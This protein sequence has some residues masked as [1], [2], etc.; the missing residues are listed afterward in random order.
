MIL[1]KLK[2]ED[3]SITVEAA[4]IIPIL[5]M[6]FLF[7]TALV[8]I[9]IA[10]MAL[11]EAVSETAQTVAHYSFLSLVIE[12]AIMDGTE[13]FID[14]IA[15][16]Q[17]KNL[18][19]NEIADYFLDKASE[20]IKNA[21]PTTGELINNHV[22]ESAYKKAVIE[23]YK[24][25]VGNSTFFSPDT[26]SII[27]SNFPNT[28]DIDVKIEVQNELHLVMPFF[29]KKIKIKKKAVERAWAGS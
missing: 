14:D 18:G 15:E 29:E 8:K 24:N 7:L 22:S 1:I 16:D 23:K 10:E 19:N 20:G 21:I 3:G 4:L 9:S 6:F 27:D 13:G 26:I 25:K 5:L 2:K 28:N 12:G 17:K 11:K